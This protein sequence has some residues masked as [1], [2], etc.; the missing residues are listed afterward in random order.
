[1]GTSESRIAKLAPRRIGESICSYIWGTCV[2]VEI[3]IG[4]CCK[5]HLFLYEHSR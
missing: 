2:P 5:L 3:G 1:M 4:T